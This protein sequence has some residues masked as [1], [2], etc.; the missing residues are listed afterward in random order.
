MRQ[1]SPKVIRMPRPT[2]TPK[3]DEQRAVLDELTKVAAEASEIRAKADAEAGAIERRV[4][5][6]ARALRVPMRE[7]V[8]RVGA[9]R[10]TVYRRLGKDAQ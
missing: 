5:A 1:E 4:I 2:W 3:T 6:K 8:A 7:V 9:A 10:A